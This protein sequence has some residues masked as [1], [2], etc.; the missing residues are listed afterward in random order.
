MV[1]WGMMIWWYTDGWRQCF[2]RAK[3]RL[4]ATLDFFSVDL[5]LK[6]LFAP[7]RQIAAGGVRGSFDAQMRAFFDRL[8]SRC[9]GTCVRLIMIFVGTLTVVGTMIV[10]GVV[11]LAWPLV[12]LMP[13]LGAVLFVMG[14]TP[15]SN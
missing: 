4:L 10:S 8:I 12:P 13:F 11:L 5:L 7:F 1:V 14:W 15:W 6:T 9:I 3:E 2:S